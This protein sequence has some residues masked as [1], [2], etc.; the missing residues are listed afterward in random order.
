MSLPRGDEYN[1]AVQN[2]VINF[3][4]IELKNSIVETTPLG[5]PKPYSGGF[6][7]TYKLINSRKNWAVRCFTR[8]IKDLDKRYQ[9]IGRFINSNSCSFLVDAKYVQNGIRIRG[10]YYPI[11]IPFRVIFPY[12]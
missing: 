5:L 6:T 10:D 12:N 3:A 2:P 1:Q 9:S 8:E 4:D 11:I 7:T